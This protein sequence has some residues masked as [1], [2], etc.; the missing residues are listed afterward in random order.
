MRPCVKAPF[1][2]LATLALPASA[3]MDAAAMQRWG[4]AKVIYY[5][6]EG[7]HSGEAAVTSKFGGR[8]DVVDRVTMDLEWV[9]TEA[10][11]QKVSNLR[12]HATEVKGLRDLEAKCPPPV[13]KGPWE[14]V[15]VLDVTNGLG[16]AIDLRLERGYPAADMAQFCGASRKA[17]PAEKSVTTES[18][19][20]PSPVLMAMGAPATKELSY[21]ADRK[22]LIYRKG[23][24]AWTF[25]PSTTPPKR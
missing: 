12:N 17:V 23:N 8:G 25:T 1:I 24:W 13:L 10:K 19:P 11:L 6:V 4:S 5:T 21:S 22:S 14:L 3:Q 7:V 9:L 18:I 15:T 20:V 16:G 2:A